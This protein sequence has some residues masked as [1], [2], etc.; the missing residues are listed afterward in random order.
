MLLNTLPINWL[1][2][3][4]IFLNWHL[5]VQPK[6]LCKINKLCCWLW[7]QPFL[8]EL[9]TTTVEQQIFCDYGGILLNVRIA[10]S[11]ATYK[12]LKPCWK[13][14]PFCDLLMKNRTPFI[15]SCN[16]TVMK[17]CSTIGIDLSRFCRHIKN[18]L[19]KVTEF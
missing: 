3:R 16:R 5:K 7:G 1:D 11:G 2:K 4:Y 19:S 12:G 15:A 17:H 18:Q 9:V 8:V 6:C 10:T 14:D 13:S